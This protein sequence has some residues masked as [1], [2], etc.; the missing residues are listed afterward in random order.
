MTI[1]VTG[2]TGFIGNRLVHD[3]LRAGHSIHALG[4]ERSAGLP[5]AVGFSEWQSTEGEP[6]PESL[7]TADAIVHLA[8]E[9]VA[10][11]WTPEVKGRIRSSRVDGTRNLVN[12]LSKQSHQPRVLVCASAIGYYGSRGDEVLTETSAPG[13]DFLSQ[14]VVDWE[15]AAREAEA[16]GIRVVSLRFGV[17]LGKDGGALAK[18]LPPFRLGLGGRLASGQQWMSW[19]HVDDV[20][21]LVRFSLDNSSA[22]GPMNATSPNPVTNAEFTRELAAAVHRPA[23]FPVPRFALN[24]LFGEMAEV[25]LGSQRVLPKAT[26]SAGFQFQYPELRPALVRL[27][28]K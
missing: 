28:S 2:A 16:V 4:R 5:Q 17:V 6:P 13:R 23:I 14:V 3:L 27:L 19:I 25:I 22:R 26:Q 11:R 18:M 20:I 21:G 12:A 8:G 9:P 15:Q 10:Q 24:L 1:T 7:A